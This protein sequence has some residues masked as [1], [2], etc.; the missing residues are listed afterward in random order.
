MEVVDVGPFKVIRELPDDTK[1]MVAWGALWSFGSRFAVGNRYMDPIPVI[2]DGA[3]KI[4]YSDPMP[5][6][7]KPG[8]EVALVIEIRAIGKASRTSQKTFPSEPT[9]VVGH[10]GGLAWALTNE[11]WIYSTRKSNPIPATL[12][13]A[14]FQLSQLIGEESFKSLISTL[15]T[16]IRK[17]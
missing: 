5:I 14:P 15:K 17:L 3:F 12:S 8:V 9:K 1:L 11:E 10:T 16:K 13:R 7:A 6:L 2:E 4:L